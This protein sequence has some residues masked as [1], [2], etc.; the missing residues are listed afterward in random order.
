LAWRPSKDVYFG[1]KL[2]LSRGQSINRYNL[3]TDERVQRR[4]PH[5]ASDKEMDDVINYNRRV[6]HPIRHPAIPA[7][8]VPEWI[9]Y[10]KKEASRLGLNVV[11]QPP[12]T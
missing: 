11:P 10:F 9:A 5:F 12:S 7:E 8:N 2:L 3:T 4:R 1:V 6:G